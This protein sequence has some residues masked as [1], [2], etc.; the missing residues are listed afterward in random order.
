VGCSDACARY[1]V[2]NLVSSESDDYAGMLQAL[3]FRLPEHIDNLLLGPRRLVT[4]AVADGRLP[5]CVSQT[6]ATWLLGREPTDEEK[7]WIDELS[8]D[9]V[10]SGFS[11]RSLIRDVLTSPVYRSQ[12]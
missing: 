9:F 5:D 12:Q 10:H 8:A 6:A 4:S 7:P 2:T 11:Y 1:Y 3:E